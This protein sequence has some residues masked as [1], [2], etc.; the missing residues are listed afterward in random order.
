ANDGSLVDGNGWASGTADP[1]SILFT[2]DGNKTLYKVSL[3]DLPALDTQF[4]TGVIAFSDG[5]S[6]P[7]D[8]ALPNDG[9]PLEFVFDPINT[10]YVE[11]TITSYEKNAVLTEV[12][13][14]SA[15]DP[16]QTELASD[17]FNSGVL[18]AGWSQVDNCGK[19]NPVWEPGYKFYGNADEQPSLRQT[20]NCRGFTVDGVEDGTYQLLDTAHTDADLR[21]MLRSDNDGSEWVTGVMGVLFGYQDDQNYY[22][23]DTN[24]RNGYRKLWKKSGDAFTE[25]AT[26]PQS[27]APG[28]RANP[29]DYSQLAWVN[30]RVVLRNGVIVVY[31]NGEKVLTAEDSTFTGGQVAMLCA[32]NTNCTFDNLV[33]LDG[34]SDPIVGLKVA[35]DGPEHV[36]GEYFVSTGSTLNIAAAVTESV[37][38]DAVEFVIND[39]SGEISVIDAV[40]PYENSFT[41]LAAGDHTVTA[42]LLD[43]AGVRF[44]EP[45]AQDI[46][47]QVAASGIHL[48]AMGDSIAAGLNDDVPDDDISHDGRN[49]GGGYPPI[50]N[51]LLAAGNLKKVTVLNNGNPGETSGEAA[52]RIQLVLTSTPEAEG[53]LL[54]YGANDSSGTTPVPSGVGLECTDIINFG[55]TC[56]SGYIGSFKYNMQRMIN[57]IQAESK[58]VYLSKTEPFNDPLNPARDARQQEY[59]V[60]IQELVDDGRN[61]LSHIPPDFYTLYTNNPALMADVHHPT[62]E[63]Y[64]EMAKLWCA[65]LNGQQGMVCNV[66]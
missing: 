19:G 21:L 40:A 53:Y 6:I 2:F 33:L 52:E 63:G 44:T 10:S 49:T 46:L 14:Y 55:A 36:S 7:V 15:L 18:A 38:F 50:L 61:N 57:A 51:N 13:A 26:S 23:F 37:G 65:A 42:Y 48:V 22:R 62:G 25:L 28:A 29:G 20:G 30:L 12:M 35:D 32:R 59:G 3:V 39:G 66:P 24:Q 4:L 27:Y 45:R 9:T 41:N 31:M 54:L 60:A 17:L 47:P 8:T 16:G 34:P 11:V 64:Q 1:A 56:D 5:T 58:Q 43:E